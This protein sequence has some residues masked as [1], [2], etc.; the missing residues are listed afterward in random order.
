[1]LS[2][3]HD[4]GSRRGLDGDAIRPKC[5]QKRLPCVFAGRRQTAVCGYGQSFRNGRWS[6]ERYQSGKT[7][8]LHLLGHPNLVLNN[9]VSKYR[10]SRTNETD[11]PTAIHT[12]A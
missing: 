1:L 2:S 10:N 11:L 5:S 9:A 3:L 4:Q 6:A 7:L 12:A 8:P